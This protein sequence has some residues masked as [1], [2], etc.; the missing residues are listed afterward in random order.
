M[1]NFSEL[2]VAPQFIKALTDKKILV[3]TEIQEKSIPYLLSIGSDFIGQAPTGTGKTAA[4]GLPLLNFVNHKVPKIQALILC[5]TRELGQQIAKQLFHY[6]LLNI[7]KRY[8]L[9]P[10]MV[11][12]ILSCRPVDYDAP[13]TF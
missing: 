12:K 6:I 10:F 13:H 2:G 4:F 11:G 8:L 9:S 1:K 5:P 3:P 7:L